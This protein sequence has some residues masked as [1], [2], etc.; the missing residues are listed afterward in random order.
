MKCWFL[1]GPIKKG[2]WLLVGDLDLTQYACTQPIVPSF[3]TQLFHYQYML[4]QAVCI[5]KPYLSPTPIY[6]VDRI[7]LE[8]RGLICWLKNYV[9]LTPIFDITISFIF[10][11]S[12]PK[13]KLYFVNHGVWNW[14]LNLVEYSNFLILLAYDITLLKL[15]LWP[16]PLNLRVT[17]GITMVF[18]QSC[19]WK[20]REK[21]KW[22]WSWN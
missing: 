21:K 16:L 15:K 4:L 6:R 17:S 11:F 22:V 13:G 14:L 18:L 3:V 5:L 1:I 12:F 9:A 20:G 2:V 19:K 8:S 7:W 10:N